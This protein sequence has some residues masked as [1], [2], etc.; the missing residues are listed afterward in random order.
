MH[1]PQGHQGKLMD[2]ELGPQTTGLAGRD[3]LCFSDFFSKL[4][5]FPIFNII[6]IINLLYMTNGIMQYILLFVK[7]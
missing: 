5:I 7:L 4:D 1:C 2:H 3:S 6:F